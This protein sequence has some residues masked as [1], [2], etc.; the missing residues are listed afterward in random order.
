MAKGFCH[1]HHRMLRLKI[2]K[3]ILGIKM[4]RMRRMLR[5]A[6][7]RGACVIRGTPAL[8]AKEERD[9]RKAQRHRTGAAEPVEDVA[10]IP[11]DPPRQRVQPKKV[12]RSKRRSGSARPPKTTGSSKPRGDDAD[13]SSA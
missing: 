10:P 8:R 7:L 1:A 12:P 13:A 9:A 11:I 6:L 2:S 4:T 5:W 3:G